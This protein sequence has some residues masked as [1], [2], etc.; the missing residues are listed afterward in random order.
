MPTVYGF[1]IFVPPEVVR[2]IF[3]AAVRARCL[4][5]ALRLRLV[6][7]SWDQEATQAL[8]ESDMLDVCP[9]IIMKASV[10]PRPL[11]RKLQPT[12][13]KLSRPL[14][15]IRQ[16]AKHTVSFR[17]R[18]ARPDNFHDLVEDDLWKICQLDTNTMNPASWF[19][20]PDQIVDIQDSDDDFKTTLLTVA[21]A[22]NDLDLVRHLLQTQ[23]D[24]ASWAV[25]INDGQVQP[26]YWVHRGGQDADNS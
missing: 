7:R 3:V 23:W 20:P 26:G 13:S 6:C 8:V 2:P 12:P 15:I 5:R 4:E 11:M 18:G 19:T 16:V 25:K 24:A 14:R 22:T 17:L 21:A 10:W 9:H 1:P